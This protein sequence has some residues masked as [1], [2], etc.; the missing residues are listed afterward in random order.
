MSDGH[1]RAARFVGGALGDA[2][3]AILDAEHARGEGGGAA[4]RAYEAA[5]ETFRRAQIEA[6]TVAL[7]YI[8]LFW[9]R[10]DAIEQRL[11]AIEQRLNT[12]V[13]RLERRADIADRV[14]FADPLS[15]Y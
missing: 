11:D 12:Q 1:D 3:R 8:P 7:G 10:L 9:E 15:P 2:W 4:Q 13:A 14:V 6:F 5:L